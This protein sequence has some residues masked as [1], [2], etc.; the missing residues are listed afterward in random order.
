MVVVKS[1]RLCNFCGAEVREDATYTH[2]M[3]IIDLAFTKCYNY[4]Y[5]EHKSKTEG[6]DICPDCRTEI[7]RCL[8]LS[9]NEKIK[10]LFK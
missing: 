7:R 1:N 3:C 8:S 6:V 10:E 4:N 2:G 5:N 9:S